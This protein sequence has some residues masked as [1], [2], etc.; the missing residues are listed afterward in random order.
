MPLDSEF[1]PTPGARAADSRELGTPGA[2]WNARKDSAVV[3]GP[4]RLPLTIQVSTGMSLLP[5]SLPACSQV[6]LAFRTC[7]LSSHT[8]YSYPIL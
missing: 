3:S 6:K 2:L 4:D 8:P 1:L 7:S 5:G